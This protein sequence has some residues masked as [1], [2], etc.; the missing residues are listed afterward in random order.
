[1]RF[2]QNLILDPGDQLGLDGTRH[3]EP[4]ELKAEAEYDDQHTDSADGQSVI[5]SPLLLAS[6]MLP[7]GSSTLFRDPLHPVL[8]HGLD[9]ATPHEPH[10]APPEPAG[11][12]ISDPSL[13][14]LAFFYAPIV[15]IAKS[16]KR[17]A[18]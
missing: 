5:S 15:V 12:E 17:A 8:S 6:E 4:A 2:T 16:T 10:Q 18:G 13:V 11:E 7:G 9:W 3:Q 1:M 14:H